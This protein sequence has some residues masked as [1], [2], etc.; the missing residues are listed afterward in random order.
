MSMKYKRR[1]VLSSIVAPMI[2][3]KDSLISMSL[4]FLS[5]PQEPLCFGAVIHLIYSSIFFL[6]PYF[7]NEFSILLSAPIKISYNNFRPA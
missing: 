6:H 4:D 2:T 1:I 5:A 3:V 7:K